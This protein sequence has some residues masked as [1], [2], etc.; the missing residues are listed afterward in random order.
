MSPGHDPA[1]TRRL[2]MP[3]LKPQW[4]ALAGAAASTIVLTLVE[5]AK[6]WPL[7]LALDEIVRS[8][9]QPFDLTAAD[10]RVLVIVVTLVVAI[11]LA[12]ALADY[13][14]DLWLYSAGE[15]ITHTLRIAAYEH[16][17]RLSLGYHQ[18][19]PTGD[20][21]ARVTED[22]TSVG[23][24]FAES[25]GAIAQGALL[26][27]GMAIVSF[28]I[29][30]LLALVSFLA[31]P[32]LALLSYRYR[33]RV[34]QGARAQR[35]HEGEIASL[36]GEALSAMSVV[37][38]S[39]SERFEGERVHVRSAERMRIG[40]EVSRLQARFDGLIGVT[41][42]VATA[43]VI[44]LGVVRISQGALSPGDLVVFATYVR[45]LNSPLRSIAREAT[46]VSR[47][48]ARADRIAEILAVD[49]LVQDRP[50][51]YSGPP[52]SGELELEH[53]TFRYAHD[54]PVL[55]DVAL[56]VPAGSCVAVIGQSG[57]GKSTVGALIVRLYDPTG[58]RVLVDGL[59]SRD[60][61]LAWLRR[62]VGVVLQETV[63][64]TGS[65]QEN[66]AYGTDAGHE[67][68]VAAARAVVA[69]EFIRALPDGYDT[70]LGPHGVGL[71]GGQR[72]RIGLARTLVRDPRI[73]VLDEPTTGLDAENEANVISGLRALMEGRTTI[74]MTHSMDL[75]AAADRVIRLHNGRIVAQGPP[76]EV[77]GRGGLAVGEDPRPLAIAD[78][79][80]GER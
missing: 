42:A 63:L 46:K 6:P 74:V 8:R 48:M 33:L 2:L 55:E 29:D 15:R 37:K 54:R 78:P 20:L 30:P 51:A 73:L 69:D 60:C 18:R 49:E 35:A 28:A 38:A 14:S 13:F 23:D 64:F 67:Q 24:L 45:R 41:S 36:A 11:A 39:G 17:Q 66:I 76:A 75:A 52:A 12:E 4:P 72:Q 31:M 22:V 5:L 26:L 65:V 62:Q 50:G 53:V 56:H 59:D 44:G 19:A 16:L 21:V 57:A 79:T 71:S 70:R 40:I 61:S 68:V 10:V 47:T 9:K 77:L 32:A 3:F 58:G 25:L 7:A 1:V 43:L 27:V 34:R 80:A